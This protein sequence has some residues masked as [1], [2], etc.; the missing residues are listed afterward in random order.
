MTVR[1]LVAVTAVAAA[2][3]SAAAPK[4]PFYIFSEKSSLLSFVRP[5]EPSRYVGYRIVEGDAVTTP[6][7][8]A[9][10]DAMPSRREKMPPPPL[11]GQTFPD[12]AVPRSATTKAWQAAH[13]NAEH[14]FRFG[15]DGAAHY[16]HTGPEGT[17]FAVYRGVDDGIEAWMWLEPKEERKGAYLVQQCLLYTGT[18]NTEKRT[19]TGRTPD[20]SEYDL[21][22]HGDVRS[23]SWVR[24]G[25]GWKQVAP[26]TGASAFRG[27]ERKPGGYVGALF[28]S[29]P[30]LRTMFFTAPGVA[31]A[32]AGGKAID[33]E[34]RIPAGLVVRE[35][36]DHLTVSGMYWE[37]TAEVS[38]HHPADCLHATVDLG[39]TSK[40]APRIVRG[41]IYDMKGT[42][43]DLFARWKRDFSGAR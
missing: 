4:T 11:T 43:D 5:A 29:V 36:A 14:F 3:A 25:N 1:T 21:W 13:E 32:E 17:R 7:P 42:K 19:R 16:R 28:A 12:P 20:L 37:R 6:A 2:S 27:A 39:P 34:R 8:L 18:A 40:H 26:P 23:L 33:E 24:D 9:G 22:E 10:Y 35:S 31:L 38:T 15:T 41:K 30:G